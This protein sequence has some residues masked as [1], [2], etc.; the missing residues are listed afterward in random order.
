MHLIRELFSLLWMVPLSLCSFFFN[1]ALIVSIKR[2]MHFK[3]DRDADEQYSGWFGFSKML[4]RPGALPYV[5]VTGPRWN[6][7]AVIGVLSRFYVSSTI[8]INAA[9][10]RQSARHWTVVVYNDKHE[11]ETFLG[12]MRDLDNEQWLKVELAPGHYYIV[13]RYY[14]LLPG[15]QFPEIK[16]GGD[17]EGFPAVAV[18]SE[19]ADYQ[20]YLA[21]IT[22]HRAAVYCGSHYYIFPLLVWRNWLP[23]AFVRREYL[24]VGNPETEFYYGYFKKNS[25]LQ[26]VVKAAALADSM[27]FITFLNRCSFPVLWESI[28]E[29]N[30]RSQPLPCDGY[31]L[32]RLVKQQEVAAAEGSIPLQCSL[33]L[34][35][36][37]N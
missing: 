27:I 23:N 26:V 33:L 11:T 24:P 30:Y 16:L 3:R 21:S 14:D 1:K 22:N 7:H 19:V 34:G 20:N 31:Y 18:A 29:L 28:T 6:C 25:V 35:D 9:T 15:A 12:T 36:T 8:E 13:L 10:A 5:M 32:I 37:V 17:S 2:L 4:Q